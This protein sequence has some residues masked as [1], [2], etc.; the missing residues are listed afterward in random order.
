MADKSH[1]RQERRGR[2]EGHSGQRGSVFAGVHG[3]P[4]RGGS[5][6]SAGGIPP[7]GGVR[8]GGWDGAGGRRTAGGAHL[9]G[10]GLRRIRPGAGGQHRSAFLPDADPAPGRSHGGADAASIGTENRG[11]DAD[12]H[13]GTVRTAGPAGEARH[14]AA[15][16][17]GD[18]QFGHLTRK[19]LKFGGIYG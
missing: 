13:G 18:S 1:V 4:H 11:G 3:R 17:H 7:A 9:P 6:E 19:S 5:D 16:T 12:V 15:G 2:R 10:D 8:P 14:G